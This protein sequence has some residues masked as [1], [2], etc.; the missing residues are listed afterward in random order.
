MDLNAIAYPDVFE[1]NGH[2]Y[3]GRRDRKK[4]EVM[5]PYTDVPA[6]SIGDL[7][8]Q[9]SGSNTIRFRVLDVAYL[10]GGSLGAGTSHPHMLTLFIE[11]LTLPEHQTPHNPTAIHIGSISGQQVQVGNQNTQ[12]TNI[13][14]SEVVQRVAASEDAEAKGLMGKLLGNSTVAAIVGA[15]ASALLGAFGA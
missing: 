3:K 1:I 5:I 6:V 7:L 8:T 14:L 11:N 13:T 4:S 12:T 2:S 10:E 9:R 15:G